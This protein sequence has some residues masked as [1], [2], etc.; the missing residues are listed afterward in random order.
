LGKWAPLKL[1]AIVA[2]PLFAPSTIGES[3]PQITSD[4]NRDRSLLRA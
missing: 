1:T 4:E 2:P 3:I